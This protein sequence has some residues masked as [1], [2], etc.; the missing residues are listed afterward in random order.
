MAASHQAAQEGIR[1]CVFPEFGPT[2]DDGSHLHPSRTASSGLFRVSTSN[3]G[4]CHVFFASLSSFILG[5]ST[6]TCVRAGLSEKPPT[7]PIF[8][9]N[10]FSAFQQTVGKLAD[11]LRPQKT[12]SRRIKGQQMQRLQIKKAQLHSNQKTPGQFCRIGHT[13]G[14]AT[15]RS[16]RLTRRSLPV[17]YVP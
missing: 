13:L 16:C 7:L 9:G 17:Y 3:S 5:S 11:G 6:W 12:K 2:P 10:R 15:L 1:H 8:R 14:Q 4:F